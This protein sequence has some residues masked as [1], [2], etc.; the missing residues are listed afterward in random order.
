MSL[1]F[2]AVN[3][4]EYCGHTTAVGYTNVLNQGAR[5]AGNRIPMKQRHIPEDR[6]N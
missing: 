2:K 3:V 5:E 1:H 6:K 4:T